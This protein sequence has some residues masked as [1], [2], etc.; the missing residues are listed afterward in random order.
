M[1]LQP[2]NQFEEETEEIGEEGEIMSPEEVAEA[3][4]TGEMVGVVLYCYIRWW[5]YNSNGGC[6]FILLHTM[7]GI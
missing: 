2:T 1:S 7:V 6:G 4:R 3:L 5:V